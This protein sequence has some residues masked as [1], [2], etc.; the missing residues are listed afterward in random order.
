[1]GSLGRHDSLI[2]M[3]QSVNDCGIGLGSAHQETYQR[4]GTATSLTYQVGR[5]TGIFILTVTYGLFKVGLNKT[6][7]HCGMRTLH[8]IGI[9]VEH[10]CL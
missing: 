2:L 6:L 8:I 1:M 7:H 3:K 10:I 4:I 9:K 5:T